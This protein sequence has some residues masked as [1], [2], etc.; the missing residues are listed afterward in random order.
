[1]EMLKKVTLI[2]ILV[3]MVLLLGMATLE[4]GILLSIISFI[5]VI[6]FVKKV[7]IKRFGVFLII[8]CLVTKIAG[9][10]ILNIPMSLDYQT[11]YDASQSAIKGDFSFLHSEYFT[12]YGYQLGHVFYQT[13]ML[14]IC[15][16]TVF[17]KIL[18][19]IYA[20][21]I[22][23]L[24]Y[25]I[26]KKFAKEDT[27]RITSLIYAISLYPV[28]LNVILGNQQLGLMLFLIGIYILLTKKNSI[29][30]RNYYWTFICIW[31]LRK[32]R[33]NNIYC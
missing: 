19:C 29:L 5:A 24:I 3:F 21:V 9:A 16:S 1:M 33:R 15:N 14:L 11:M 27:A 30:N 2:A 22:T 17:L 4:N 25:A 8:F 32:T 31:K 18:N 28:Y 13:L 7:R 20:T 10:L 26:V 12:A 6:F 23:W